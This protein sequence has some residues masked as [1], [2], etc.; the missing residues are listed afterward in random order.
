V[1]ATLARR[2]GALEATAR[3]DLEGRWIAAVDRMRETMAPEHARL[4]A[5]WLREQV[6]GKQY[7]PHVDSPNHVCPRCIDRLDPPALARAVWFMLLDHLTSGALVAMPPNV[8]GVYLN[9]PQAY[10]A[11]RCEECGYLLPARSK[12]R[13]DGSYR[14]MARYLGACPVCGLDTPP[15]VQGDAG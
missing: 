2:L 14:H 15:E 8:A 7:G 10:P 5:T 1:T 3:Q 6:N 13:P 12:I 9:D 4:V 11:D